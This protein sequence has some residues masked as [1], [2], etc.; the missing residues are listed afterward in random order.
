[1]PLLQREL[2]HCARM[3]K[4]SPQQYLAQNEHILFDAS[5]SSSP[6]SQ[7]ISVDI[8]ENGK[9]R[10]PDRWVQGRVSYRLVAL[11]TLHTKNTI[12]GALTLVLVLECLIYLCK[13]S[14][15]E[16]CKAFCFFWRVGGGGGGQ[17][18]RLQKYMRRKIMSYD[19]ISLLSVSTYN[20]IRFILFSD[21]K[22]FIWISA[23]NFANA[24]NFLSVYNL[25]G[26]YLW[27]WSEK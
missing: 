17:L 12:Y 25:P 9:R 24:K 1:M 5:N 15:P 3:A 11:C 23:W 16:Y 13:Y 2:L 8:N 27:N 10:S 20:Y 19:F 18:Q 6:E 4:Q 26:C 21:S 22:N 14:K 7:D